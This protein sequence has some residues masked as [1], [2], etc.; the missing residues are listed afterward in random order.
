[1]IRLQKYLAQ[2]GVSSRRKAE[3]LI[4][5]GKVIVNDQVISTV[6]VSIDPSVDTVV[7]NGKKLKVQAPELYLFYKPKNV[8]TTL[9]DPQKRKCVG[10]F[11]TDFKTRIYPIG[12]LDYNV[13]GLLLLTN[14]GEYA[15]QLLHPKYEVERTYLAFVE[16][17]V[18]ESSLK[19]LKKG[20]ELDDGIAKA[21]RV[22]ILPLEEAGK[23]KHFTLPSKEN[24]SLIELVAAEGRKHFV[25]RILAAIG[26]PVIELCRTAYGQY[27]LG[28]MRPGEIKAFKSFNKP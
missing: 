28:K 14:D 11:L 27:E 13:Q 16:G 15:N 4:T 18:K 7:V 6:G 10:D 20:I 22:K 19:S 5:Q 23:F 21:K 8:I 3:D 9:D 24:C 1:M 25:K 26:H 17:V 12:R 2:C